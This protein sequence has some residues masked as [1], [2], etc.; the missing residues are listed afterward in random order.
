MHKPKK[1]KRVTNSDTRLLGFKAPT[2]QAKPRFEY[3]L[4]EGQSTA[5]ESV[6]DD[7]LGKAE[8]DLH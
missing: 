2:S 8:R 1:H 6:F 4:A 3:R 5:L 7:L